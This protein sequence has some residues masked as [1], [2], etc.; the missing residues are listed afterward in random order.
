MSRNSD[1]FKDAV[2]FVKKIKDPDQKK[3]IIAKIRDNPSLTQAQAANEIAAENVES[4]LRYAKTDN[5][6]PIQILT[7]IAKKKLD[8]DK[9]IATGEEIPDVIRKL[10]GEEKI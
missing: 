6:D 9:F 1:V 5:K 8:M 2:E 7:S 4:I 3:R 10:L